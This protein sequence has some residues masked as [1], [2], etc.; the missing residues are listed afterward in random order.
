MEARIHPL[1]LIPPI[2]RYTFIFF[3][4]LQ[5]ILSI[6]SCHSIRWNF[7][8][9]DNYKIG[10]DW[11]ALT[12]LVKPVANPSSTRRRF[13]SSLIFA[14][15]S[16]KSRIIS[17]I[18]STMFCVHRIVHAHGFKITIIIVGMWWRIGIEKLWEGEGNKYFPMSVTYAHHPFMMLFS[19][20]LTLH[21][22]TI[23]LGVTAA[24][25]IEA[26]LLSCFSGWR[27]TLC[28]V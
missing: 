1:S 9:T 21:F 7:L 3:P 16:L 11:R 14:W 12:S 26:I 27:H 19:A 6:Y 23:L 25:P 18:V 15:A 24:A 17:P 13:S 20:S 4:S 2:G 28:H 22:V 5:T 8:S 10:K